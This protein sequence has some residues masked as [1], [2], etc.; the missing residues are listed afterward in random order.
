[1]LPI[2]NFPIGKPYDGSIEISI[3]QSS[4]SE[5]CDSRSTGIVVHMYTEDLYLR[6]LKACDVDN[7][8]ALM[9]D[10][11]TVKTYASGQPLPKGSAIQRGNRWVKRWQSGN[12]Y[13]ALAVFKR[14]PEAT[15]QAQPF[16][17][18]I[19]AGAGECMWYGEPGNYE[20]YSEMAGLGYK[21]YRNKGFGKQA[22]AA[23]IN[24]AIPEY[25]QKGYGVETIFSEE[26]TRKVLPL[27]WV[28]A[29]A[30]PDNIA[31]VKV[32]T[33]LGFECKK[34]E[35]NQ[36]NRTGGVRAFFALKV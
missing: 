5:A 12:P 32:L 8:C 11:E 21:Q 22:A 7:Y 19:V 6:S 15:G 16:V 3:E 2:P 13:S 14:S 9:G 29:T 20:G 33:G 25:Q 17:G 1:M 26:R 24:K 31:S 18:Y 30:A 27:G 4:E 10:K 23:L 28:T 35:G 36:Y 34:V